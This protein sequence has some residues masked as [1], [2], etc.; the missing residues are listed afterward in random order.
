MLELV[1]EP[2]LM[3]NIWNLELKWKSLR[4]SFKTKR[5]ILDFM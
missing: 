1:L 4:Y 2:L 3:I 5:T